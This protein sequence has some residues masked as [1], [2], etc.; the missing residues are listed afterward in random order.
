MA[1]YIPKN[2]PHPWEKMNVH[3][4]R[5]R[6][7]GG[8]NAPENLVDLSESDHCLAHLLLYLKYGRRRDWEAYITLRGVVMMRKKKGLIPLVSMGPVASGKWVLYV[9]GSTIA[10]GMSSKKECEKYWRM[11]A[12][13]DGKVR[14]ASS[15]DG[16]PE[17]RR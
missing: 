5:P 10:G 9:N 6:S 7:A 2:P 3:H 4:I 12:R 15:V 8:N 11:L 14:Q 1:W 16:V 17:T 13:Q